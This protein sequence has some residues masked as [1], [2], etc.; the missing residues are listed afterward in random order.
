MVFHALDHYCKISDKLIN[1]HKARIQIAKGKT[2]ALKEE[3]TNILQIISTGAVGTYLGCSNI[4]QKRTNKDFEGVRCRIEEK[5][6][7]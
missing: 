2:E 6:A 7:S 3:I 5:L 4:D 1:D